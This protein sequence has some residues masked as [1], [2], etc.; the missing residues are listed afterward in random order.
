MLSR[1]IV[2]VGAGTLLSLPVLVVALFPVFVVA[3]FLVLIV[4]LFPVL[5]VALPDQ[6][7]TRR[8]HHY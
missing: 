4:A 5:V 1:I 7:G 6:A 3:L 2:V 8:L